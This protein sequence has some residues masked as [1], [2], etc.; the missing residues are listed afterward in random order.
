MQGS[1]SIEHVCGT[2]DEVMKVCLTV[3]GHILHN[4][5]VVFKACMPSREV[6]ELMAKSVAGVALQWSK[7]SL[8][9]LTQAGTA[10]VTH[11]SMTHPLKLLS[12]RP[13]IF[14]AERRYPFLIKPEMMGS[15]RLLLYLTSF[16]VGITPGAKKTLNPGGC[17][18]LH[19]SAHINMSI[20]CLNHHLNMFD[21]SNVF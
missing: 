3:L 20:C 9:L 13:C 14:A 21:D 17:S 16:F 10:D 1:K 12:H 6:L 7:L 2:S 11:L 18:V 15:I 5:V 8:L 19:I 4:W